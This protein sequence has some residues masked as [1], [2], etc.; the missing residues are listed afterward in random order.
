MRLT[1]WCEAR[2]GA[3]VQVFADENGKLMMK[4]LAGKL[5]KVEKKEQFFASLPTDQFS[6]AEPSDATKR[7]S[8]RRGVRG[9]S[10]LIGNLDNHVLR[11]KQRKS[12]KNTN[13]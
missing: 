4:S 5:E 2:I 13:P 8:W 11:V 3:E 7:G 1:E 9:A 10:G 6:P 12:T